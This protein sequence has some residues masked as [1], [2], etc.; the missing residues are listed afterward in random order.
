M[1]SPTWTTFIILVVGGA[2]LASPALSFSPSTPQIMVTR[3]AILQSA[4]FSVDADVPTNHRG[5]E[6][7]KPKKTSV[8]FHTAILSAVLTLGT[9]FSPNAHID[10]ANTQLSLV[11]PANA[12]ES[13]VVGSLKGSGLVF[14]DTLQIERFED[15]KVQGVVLY[16]SNFDRPITEK[17]SGGNFFNDPSYASV[18]CARTGPVS[19]AD[20]IGKGPQGEEV[21]EESRSLLFK[22][23]RVQRVYDEEKKTV[24]YVSYNTR[25]DKSDDTNKSRFKSSLC[26][27]NLE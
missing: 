11:P 8:S 5:P 14:K 1:R 10:N 24:V 16:I 19:I 26:A 7:S 12:A 25:L 18:A 9:V 22:T 21:F 27:V 3:T 13:K 4:H 20:N 15:P 23:L 17:L 6:S 2:F